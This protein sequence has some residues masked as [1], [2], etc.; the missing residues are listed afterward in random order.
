[1]K[2][3]KI[4]SECEKCYTEPF[5]STSLT[6]TCTAAIRE[7]DC[8]MD[9]LRRKTLSTADWSAFDISSPE[10]LKCPTTV[11]W[12]KRVGARS[13]SIIVLSIFRSGTIN[14]SARNEVWMGA[15]VESCRNWYFRYLATWGIVGK[16]SCGRTCGGPSKPS[17]SRI[18]RL[19]CS[20][21]ILANSS[22]ASAH[23]W[24]LWLWWRQALVPC[25]VQQQN[26]PNAKNIQEAV[27]ISI[28]MLW[29][30]ADTVLSKQREDQERNRAGP[31]HQHRTTTNRLRTMCNDLLGMMVVVLLSLRGVL[32]ALHCRCSSALFLRQLPCPPP[33]APRPPIAAIYQTTI[34]A[35]AN[36]H[37]SRRN[38]T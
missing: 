33:G 10:N 9:G 8:S 38:H 21:R 31:S 18:S 12:L 28:A 16:V 23:P 32:F 26:S 17:F 7:S 34:A 15:V 20:S 14:S 5:L 36:Y 1:M 4:K 13:A 19:I 25:V 30:S 29:T 11:L 22:R 27:V 35:P 6:S 37:Y 24:Q 3:D 2:R